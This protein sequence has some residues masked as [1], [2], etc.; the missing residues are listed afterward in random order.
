M[1][2]TTLSLRVKSLHAHCVMLSPR[3][4]AF[5]L[6]DV[7]I[8]IYIYMYSAILCILSCIH[9]YIYTYVLSQRWRASAL[10]DV[11]ICLYV[12]MYSAI[13]CILSCV[14]I[15]IYTY[16][17]S[18]RWRASA[19]LDVM[20]IM[21]NIVWGLSY[22]WPVWQYGTCGYGDAW[23]LGHFMGHH[24]K[25]GNRQCGNR[26]GLIHCLLH[27]L[28]HTRVWGHWMSGTLHGTP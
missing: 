8:G 12:Y 19:L 20:R 22:S 27:C 14:H 16:V 21:R 4:W 1:T 5:P 11:Y 15:Y 7:Y 9:V 6:V 2:H 26:H 13:L 23:C 17:L 10:V 25:C 24:R 18:R 28:L 3:W